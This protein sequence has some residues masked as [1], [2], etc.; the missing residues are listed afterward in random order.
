[1]VCEEPAELGTGHHDIKI[2][3]HTGLGN[4]VN[5]IYVNIPLTLDSVSPAVG[6]RF[7]GLPVTVTGS[8]FD[9]DTIFSFIQNGA[10]LCSPC[11]ILEMRSG[12]EFVIQTPSSSADGAAKDRLKII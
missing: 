8:G 7:G 3:S 12:N 1:M 5:G 9:E 11:A 2:T 6:S 10:Y 4:V